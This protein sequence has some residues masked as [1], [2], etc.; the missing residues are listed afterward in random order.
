MDKYYVATIQLLTI[1][2]RLP[3]LHPVRCRPTASDVFRS[4]DTKATDCGPDEGEPGTGNF[5]EQVPCLQQRS[6][7]AAPR[8]RFSSL[9][10]F[11]AGRVL[12]TCELRR[13]QQYRQ[14]QHDPDPMEAAR[15]AGGH[16]VAPAAACDPQEEQ[17][18]AKAL[19]RAEQWLQLLNSPILQ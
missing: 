12:V 9:P 17:N 1:H 14:G 8:P 4:A 6:V 11:R 5:P 10:S 7:P 19:F 2:Y 15:D 18:C 13:E 3:L 16:S